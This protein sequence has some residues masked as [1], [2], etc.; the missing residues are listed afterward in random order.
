MG[1]SGSG[2]YTP[3][4]PRSSCDELLFQATV[5]SPQPAA[6]ADLVIGQILTL[7]AAPSGAAVNVKHGKSLVGAL[8]GTQ[9]ARL[10][11]CMHMGFKYHA[12]VVK[13][14]GGQCV[15]RVE[16]E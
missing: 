10:I 7:T 16:S 4:T 12:I 5:N 11:N 1:G 13:V 9:V 6:L 15:V 3:T 8:T 14:R 2:G